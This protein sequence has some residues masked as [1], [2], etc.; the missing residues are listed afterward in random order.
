MQEESVFGEYGEYYD[1]LNQDKDYK[2]E[3]TYI[4]KLL[5]KHQ[6][7]GMD[8]LEFGSGTGKHAA[9]LSD[10]GYRILG[11]ERSPKMVGEA[12]KIKNS[13]FQSVIGDIRH[14]N[15]GRVFDAVLS[16]FHVISYQADNESLHAVFKNASRHLNRNGLFLFDFWYGPAVLT[17]KPE[18]RVKRIKHGDLNITRI[19]EPRLITQDNSVDVRF[20]I[21]IFNNKSGKFVSFTE[22][23]LMRYF[24][25]PELSY[26]AKPFNLSLVSAEEFLTSSSLSEKTWG[27]C[28]V[29]RKDN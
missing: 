26:I 23:H 12:E 11:V 9:L 4:D 21:Q 2:A 19:A 6:S 1:A 28:V 20:T 5:K 17:Q 25:I 14:L 15:T 7:T 22:N 16:M 13:G 18:V 8:V 29:F 3:V 27:A 24:S 10:M